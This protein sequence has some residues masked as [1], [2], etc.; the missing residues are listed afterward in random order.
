VL[1]TENLR[2]Q[3]FLFDVTKEIQDE[4]PDPFLLSKEFPPPK[5]EMME[6]LLFFSFFASR[7]HFVCR[8]EFSLLP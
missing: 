6:L 4:R 2:S 1:R 3:V 7:V 5:T 8:K